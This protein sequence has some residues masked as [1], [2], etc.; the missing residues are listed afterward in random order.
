M[1]YSADD[2]AGALRALLPPGRVWRAEPGSVQA[3]VLGA[4]AQTPARLDEAASQLLALSRP[5]DNPDL[6]VEWE[7]S[8]GL[9]DPCAGPAP[10]ISERAHQVR[11]RFGGGGG[12]SAAF[13]IAYAAALGFTI[14]I[15]TFAAFRADVGTVESPVFEDDW[16]FAWGVTVTANTSGLSNDVLACEFEALKPAQTYVFLI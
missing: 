16:N 13:F 15:T 2:Y 3:Q 7:E 4:L 5:G 9:P 12:Q 14:T 8:L 6:L 10:T 11:A 1:P